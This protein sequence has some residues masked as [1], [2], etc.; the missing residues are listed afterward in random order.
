MDPGYQTARN[1]LEDPLGRRGGDLGAGR[2]PVLSW[3][4]PGETLCAGSI[5]ERSSSGN[6]PY[7]LHVGKEATCST[8]VVRL[9]PSRDARHRHHSVAQQSAAEPSTQGGA[10]WRQWFKRARVF[11]IGS[12]AWNG[13]NKY[14]LG[15]GSLLDFLDDQGQRLATGK[16]A[17]LQ[18]ALAHTRA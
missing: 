16:I 4:P 2:A 11:A 5:G 1:L 3:A 18:W 8:L 9:R 14:S 13:W 6:G 12:H 15:I 17:Q 10:R 7:V